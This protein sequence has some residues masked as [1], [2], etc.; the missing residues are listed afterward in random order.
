MS[1]TIDGFKI[2]SAIGGRP[3]LFKTLRA[4]VDK[5]AG[6]M[7]RKQLKDKNTGVQDFRAIRLAIGS[8]IF[9]LTIDGLSDKELMAIVKKLDKYHPE[10]PTADAKWLGRHLRDLSASNSEPSEKPVPV[11][12]P[13]RV[14]SAGRAKPSKPKAVPAFPKS[15]SAKPSRL[16]G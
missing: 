1:T 10:L 11:A 12:K 6:G 9:D 5:A 14:V 16:R 4:D 13:P 7:I 3:D 2:F 15:M 8:D